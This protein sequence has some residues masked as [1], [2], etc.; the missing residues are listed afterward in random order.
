M[1]VRGGRDL[2]LQQRQLL[3]V[4]DECAALADEFQE[5]IEKQQLAARLEPLW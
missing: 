5:V 3:P 4:L 2:S 1:L